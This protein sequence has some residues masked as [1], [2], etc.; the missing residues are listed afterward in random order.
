MS[1]LVNEKIRTAVASG[2][3]SYQK[4]DF[5]KEFICPEESMRYA[6]SLEQ[7]V[8]SKF[9]NALEKP[10]IIE[11]GSGT[12]APVV[13]A[14]LNSKFSGTVHGYEINPEASETADRLIEDNGLTNQYI[15]HNTSFFETKRIVDADYLIANPPYVPCNDQSLLTLPDLCG[16]PEGNEI[17]KKLLSCGYKNVFLEVSSYSNPKSLLEHALN[18]GYKVTDFQITQLPFGIYSRQPIVQTRIQEMRESGKAFFSNNCYLVGST[19]F[20]K[21]THEQDLSSELLACLTSLKL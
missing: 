17:S 13:T 12:G 15:I 2:F 11:F 5:C 4:L 8:F 7:L 19:F 9:R 14:I 3:S 20:A 18:L 1:A 6:G 16:G 10:T 21:N